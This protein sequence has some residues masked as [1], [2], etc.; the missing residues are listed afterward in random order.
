MY[1][2]A[3]G[4]LAFDREQQQEE[5]G[6][7]EAGREDVMKSL[8]KSFELFP[9]LVSAGGRAITQE[10]GSGCGSGNGNGNGHRNETAIILGFIPWFRVPVLSF[11]EILHVLA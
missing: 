8:S 1:L 7:G 4:R 3:D 5:E 9:A 11:E 2:D 6:E 10:K